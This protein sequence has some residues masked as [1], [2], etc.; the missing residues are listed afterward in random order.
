MLL[1]NIVVPG[2]ISELYDN[3]N[4]SNVTIQLK[5]GFKYAKGTNFN[6]S[7]VNIQCCK[8]QDIKIL[9]LFQYI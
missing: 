2:D 3:F 8:E 7:N 5:G 1:F 9:M 6:T 4:T